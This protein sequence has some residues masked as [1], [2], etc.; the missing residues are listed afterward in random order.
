MSRLQSSPISTN[1]STPTAQERYLHHKKQL[2][3]RLITGMD[4]S[5][6]GAMKE[7]ELRLE[8]RRVAEELSAP[9]C[10]PAQPV[11]ARAAGQRSPGRDIRPGPARGVDA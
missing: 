8:V 11:R 5:A 4:L 3:E 10:R 7:D 9:E 6:I 2:H 1:G